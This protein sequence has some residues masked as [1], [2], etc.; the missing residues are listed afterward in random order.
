MLIKLEGFLLC[1]TACND[2]INIQVR[3]DCVRNMCVVL[4]QM[5][6]KHSKQHKWELTDPN[7]TV[8]NLY[9]K[10]LLFGSVGSDSQRNWVKLRSFSCKIMCRKGFLDVGGN[11]KSV[12]AKAKDY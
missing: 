5:V 11:A 9:V 1:V 4:L 7:K 10:N 12:S 2:I 6:V 8:Q 3:A